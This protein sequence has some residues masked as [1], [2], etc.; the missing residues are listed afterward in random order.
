MARVLANIR[1]AEIADCEQ[2]YLF[3]QFGR[4]PVRAPPDE[5]SGRMR[6]F[7]P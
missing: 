1:A 6:R 4:R 2:V 5:Q 3:S 7:M